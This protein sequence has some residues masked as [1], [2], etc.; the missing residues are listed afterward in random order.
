[1]EGLYKYIA[2]YQSEIW[3]VMHLRKDVFGIE[4]ESTI[5]SIFTDEKK[6][7]ACAKRYVY[8]KYMSCVIFPLSEHSKKVLD[9]F[10]DISDHLPV[11]ARVRSR[12]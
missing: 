9:S 5:L 6:A 7:I 8:D 4:P 11:M 1:M 3:V 12:W 10:G 2:D